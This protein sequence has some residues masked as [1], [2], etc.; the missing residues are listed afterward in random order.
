MNIRQKR[1]ADA[2]RTYAAGEIMEYEQFHTHE[3][4][5]INVTEVSITEDYEYADIYVWSQANEHTLPHFLAPC[6]DIIRKKIGKDFSLRKIPRIRIR[7]GKQKNATADIL[8]LIQSL[9]NQYGLSQE[10]P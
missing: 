1:L 6:A 8:S 9:D 7:I 3:F 5:I 4:G 10:N 2:L